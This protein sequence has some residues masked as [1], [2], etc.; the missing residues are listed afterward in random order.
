[1]I[2]FTKENVLDAI[3]CMRELIEH[4]NTDDGDYIRRTV[5]DA[6]RDVFANLGDKEALEAIRDLRGG[7]MIKN[8]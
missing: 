4:P 8:G 7:T 1:M 6:V 3:D 2:D 5:R